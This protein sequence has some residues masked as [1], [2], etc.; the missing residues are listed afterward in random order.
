MTELEHTNVKEG[1]GRAQV[2][3]P[4][5]DEELVQT[6]GPRLAFIMVGL[7]LAVFLTGMV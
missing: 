5:R 2:D 4:V 7:C 3:T 6:S 1:E